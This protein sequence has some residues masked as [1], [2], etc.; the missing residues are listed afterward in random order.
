M[1]A[2]V[3]VTAVTLTE[4][5]R[6]HCSGITNTISNPNITRTSNSR[7]FKTSQIEN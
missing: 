4:E 3:E 6:R 2:D 1:T 7:R 5:E